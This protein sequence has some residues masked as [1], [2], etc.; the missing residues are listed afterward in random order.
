MHTARA[1]VSI[2]R[3]ARLR[4][5]CVRGTEAGVMEVP[6]GI[7]LVRWYAGPRLSV[8]QGSMVKRY[9]QSE[10]TNELRVQEFIWKEQF[11]RLLTGGVLGR[12][13]GWCR[14]VG[15]RD[16]GAVVERIRHGRD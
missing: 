11:W 12:A 3:L 14:E 8:S 9:P 16:V 4:M 6:V 7:M 2:G 10:H 1:M 15:E 13:H 5:D